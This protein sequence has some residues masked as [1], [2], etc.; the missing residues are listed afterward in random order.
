[1]PLISL[2]G[3]GGPRWSRAVLMYD[4]IELDGFAANSSYASLWSLHHQKSK[5]RA[6]ALRSTR[7]PVPLSFGVGVG[8]RPVGQYED[9]F[10]TVV[11]DKT[12]KVGEKGKNWYIF[13]PCGSNVSVK[14][15]SFFEKS[16]SSWCNFSPTFEIFRFCD[17]LLLVDK[18]PAEHSSV[19]H[20][21]RARVPRC[22]SL[23]LDRK[24]LQNVSRVCRQDVLSNLH[25]WSD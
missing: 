23:G 18:V 21:V 11:C 6:V 4:C 3:D 20:S 24:L 12:K 14:S 25:D 22:L 9:T 16:F 2:I 5:W 8:R 15:S 13:K 1:M 10:F 7:S 17:I 19:N